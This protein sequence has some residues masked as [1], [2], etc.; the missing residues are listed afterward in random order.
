VETTSAIL[1]PE[2]SYI[3]RSVA[4]VTIIGPI[5]AGLFLPVRKDTTN[6]LL[7]SPDSPYRDY[8]EFIALV[9]L[10]I[11]EDMDPYLCSTELGGTPIGVAGKVTYHGF[12]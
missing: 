11:E 4:V 5:G 10:A 6:K 12:L 9:L 8:V 7:K 3:G 2:E 1:T